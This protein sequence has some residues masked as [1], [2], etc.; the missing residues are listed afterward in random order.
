MRRLRYEV[1]VHHLSLEEDPARRCSS[2][3]QPCEQDELH[4]TVAAAFFRII[5]A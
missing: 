5:D 2:R 3:C 4:D 1:D